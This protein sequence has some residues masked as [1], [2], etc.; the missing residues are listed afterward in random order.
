[1]SAA[2]AF[3]VTV[4]ASSSDR[5]DPAFVA[6]AEDLGRRI[7]ERGWDLVWGG[8]RHGLMGA[9]SRG[10]RA[11]GGRTIGVILQA[12]VDKNVHCTDAHEMASVT[13]MRL[14]KRGLDESGDA[15]VALPG[16]LGTMEELLEVLS[17]RQLGLHRKPIVV[18][19]ALGYWQPLLAM[20]EHGF[21]HGFIQPHFRGLWS[22]ARDPA[23]AIEQIAAPVRAAAAPHDPRGGGTA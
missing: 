5:I 3:R 14:R 23:Q 20:L 22:V 8:G 4:Y 7:A 2:R 11:A 18:L 9:V 21:R 17:F 1:M 19:D 16:G 6:I 10:A 12:F 15:F 13:D